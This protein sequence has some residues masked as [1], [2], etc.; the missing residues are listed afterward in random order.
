MPVHGLL[1]ESEDGSV[2]FLIEP[3]QERVV[4]RRP[5]GSD[6]VRVASPLISR[7][8]ARFCGDAEG[9]TVEDAG[10]TSGI[11][12][13]EVRVDRARVTP[14]SRLRLGGVAFTVRRFAGTGAWELLRQAPVAPADALAFGRDVLAGL[15]ALHRAG[16]RHGVLTPNEIVRDPGGRWLLLCHG[17][18]P[19]DPDGPI[20]GNP[21]YAAPEL[22]RGAASGPM[23][24][25]YAL[26]LLLFE[27]LS[28][29]GAFPGGSVTEQIARK[30]AGTLPPW[31]AP[32]P[33]VRA[34]VEQLL[35]QDAGARAAA[36]RALPELAAV[37]P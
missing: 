24:D 33:A 23:V 22:L 32:S 6:S 12:L 2:R 8:H 3:G 21:R 14:G 26:G 20:P 25:L 37:Y 1:V 17:W 29:Q 31:A 35:S 16:R 9:A 28:G 18:D 4:G 15:A 30:L 5:T 27:L 34:C 10:S 36:V 11:W 13:D 7:Q 19:S